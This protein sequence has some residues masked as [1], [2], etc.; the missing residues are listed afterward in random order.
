MESNVLKTGSWT[1]AEEVTLTK[2]SGI[3]RDGTA[4][5]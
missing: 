2:A 1:E 5:T 3:P 4:V